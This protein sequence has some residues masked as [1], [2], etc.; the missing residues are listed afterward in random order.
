M[1]SEVG[2][3]RD[4]DRGRSG[5]EE[6]GNEVSA[7]LSFALFGYRRDGPVVPHILFI[8]VN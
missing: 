2:V 4:R 6:N 5:N 8:G 1:Q 3:S 7:R